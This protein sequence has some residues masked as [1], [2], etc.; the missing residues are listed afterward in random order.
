MCVY[1]PTFDNYPPHCAD[2]FLDMI[3]KT[4]GKERVMNLVE[5]SQ[6][7]PT[8]KRAMYEYNCTHALVSF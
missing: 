8:Q 2:I 7:N 1:V 4:I 6:E 3:F 5:I